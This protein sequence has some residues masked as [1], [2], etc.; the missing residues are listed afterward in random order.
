MKKILAIGVLL[1]F[2]VGCI[3]VL[4]KDTNVFSKDLSKNASKDN[5]LFSKNENDRAINSS[6]STSEI[7]KDVNEIN[8]SLEKSYTFS[9]HLSSYQEKNEGNLLEGTN[10][11]G[12][13]TTNFTFAPRRLEDIGFIEPM[14]LMLGD[15]VTPIDHQYYY[16]PK[17][18]ENVE[19]S[20]LK[21]VL[22]PGDG[23]I[24]EIQRMPSFFTKIKKEDMQDYRLIIQHTC[25]FYSI[26]IHIYVLSPKIKTTLGDIQP[27]EN[28]RVNVPVSAGEVIG[29]A[30]SFD[31]SVHDDTIVLSGFIVQEHYQRE[32]WKIH[33]VDPFNYFV[34]PLKSE[35]L[36]K[37]IRQANPR[38]GKIDNDVDGKLI[39]N[40]FV[41]N[42]NGYLGIKQPDYW[43]TH[44]SFSPDVIDPSH[45]IVSLGS[46]EGT[47]K[48]FGVLENKP[49]P[50]D[51]SISSG[52]IVYELVD[53]NYQTES[54]KIWDGKE[55]ANTLHAVN[56]KQVRG[57]VLIELLSERTL[58]LEIF[59]SKK[60]SDVVGFTEH[61]IVYER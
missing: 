32:P 3:N 1:F 44:V 42:T 59:P 13:G 49:L 12:S 26:Y 60:K 27:S 48:Q 21:D 34:E 54:G 45:F 52:K 61:A 17:W 37:D 51:V 30:N 47:A 25:T 20:D 16:P 53:Y 8:K 11:K 28:K 23:I 58:K 19:L 22:A 56:Q 15:H 2:L 33:T 10:C 40:W 31:F 18:K 50:E 35:L 29:Q 9:K 39:G 43:G 57:T 24:T 55:Y 4:S 5:D 38:G 7:K 36:A 41:Q 14:G 6:I 46:Y